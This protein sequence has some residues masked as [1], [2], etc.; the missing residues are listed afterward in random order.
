MYCLKQVQ[1]PI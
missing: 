1:K